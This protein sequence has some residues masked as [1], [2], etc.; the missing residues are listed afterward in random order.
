[1]DKF[2]IARIN[3]LK[4][5]DKRGVSLSEALRLWNNATGKNESLGNFSNKMR[6]GSVRYIDVMEIADALGYKIE[7]VKK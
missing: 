7:W 6:R 5:L 4:Q 1:M 3:I 2:N